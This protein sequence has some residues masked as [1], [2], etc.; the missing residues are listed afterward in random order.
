MTLEPPA[1][2]VVQLKQWLKKRF[3]SD[4]QPP[5]DLLSTIKGEITQLYQPQLQQ[6]GDDPIRQRVEQLY[7]GQS[8]NLMQ[9]ISVDPNPQE[10][11]VNLIQTTQ[12]DEIRWQ[13][14]ELLWELNPHHPHCPVAS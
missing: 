4:W 5:Q 9:S 12:D 8:S 2:P 7:R 14:A 13:S 1:E 10:T 6:R 3:E 11:L